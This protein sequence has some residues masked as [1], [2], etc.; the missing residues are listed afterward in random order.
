MNSP[1]G[2]NR[3]KMFVA[4]VVILKSILHENCM[5]SIDYF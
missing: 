4:A 5:E 3:K 1:W 2:G